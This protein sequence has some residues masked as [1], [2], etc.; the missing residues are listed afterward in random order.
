MLLDDD[1][2]TDGEPKTGSFS[3]RLSREE[4]IEQLAPHLG[5]NAGTVVADPDF[6]AVAEVFGGGSRVGS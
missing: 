6:D 1:I 5:R 3:G 4:W 2:V